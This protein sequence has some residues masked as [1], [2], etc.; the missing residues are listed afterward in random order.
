MKSALESKDKDKIKDNIG[1]ILHIKE[2]FLDNWSHDEKVMSGLVECIKDPYDYIISVLD[3]ERKDILSGYIEEFY[4]NG[5]TELAKI[6][7]I[8][9]RN[10]SIPN[11][12]KEIT[13][14]GKENPKSWIYVYLKEN[15][16]LVPKPDVTTDLT[17]YLRIY[18]SELVYSHYVIVEGYDIKKCEFI[19]NGY[20]D[21]IH[22][23]ESTKEKDLQYIGSIQIINEKEE[24]S[25]KLIFQI[26]NQTYSLTPFYNIDVASSTKKLFNLFSKE[27]MYIVKM[28]GYIKCENGLL[29]YENK[30]RYYL[31]RKHQ[32]T[33]RLRFPNKELDNIYWCCIRY[34]YGISVPIDETAEYLLDGTPIIH[35][36]YESKKNHLDTWVSKLKGTKYED[37]L[38]DLIVIKDAYIRLKQ[39]LGLL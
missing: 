9:F 4:S 33:Y 34:I 28:R 31:V 32:I 38:R 26:D 12:Y 19:K 29:Q 39:V 15:K 10:M 35:N 2:F 1:K 20:K 22:F 13:F 11:K 21:L 36:V 18:R 14:W 23:V 7:Y 24:G 27:T 6:G 25:K 3:T 5:N 17:P 16:L 8:Y 37:Q 30:E